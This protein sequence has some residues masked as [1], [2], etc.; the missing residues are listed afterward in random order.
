[1]DIPIVVGV[2]TATALSLHNYF[3]TELDIYFEAPLM[4]IFFLLIGRSVEYSLRDRI[5]DAASILL[6]QLQ[7][8]VW[9]QQGNSYNQK[10]V[11][12]INTGDVIRIAMG[13]KIKLDGLLIS[14][15]NAIIDNS[16]FSG[17]S[18]PVHYQQGSKIYAGMVNLGDNI[19]IR[20]TATGGQTRLAKFAENIAKALD[21]R[22]KYH[23]LAL[24]I[25]R[26]YTPLVHILALLTFGLWFADNQTSWQQAMTIAVS[27]L[28]IT[29]PCALGLATPLAIAMTSYRLLKQGILLK[30][31]A[32]IERAMQV[33]HIIFDKTGTLTLAEFEFSN[34]DSFDHGV[35]AI[36]KALA[37]HS[38]HP[39]C[40]SLLTQLAN[41]DAIANLDNIKEHKGQGVSAILDGKEVK[42][43]NANFC[44]VMTADQYSPLWLSIDG[45]TFAIMMRDTIKPD[46]H[47]TIV[48]LRHMGYEI[49]LISGDIPPIVKEVADK[50][51]IKA[52]HSQMSHTQKYQYVKH[53]TSQHGTLMIGDG[54]NDAESLAVATASIA[55][56]KALD[57]SQNAADVIIPHN[58]LTSVIS[59]LRIAYNGLRTIKSNLLVALV[60]NVCVVP[61]AILGFINPPLAAIFM[62]V[63]SITVTLMS[64]F[65]YRN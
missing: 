29:C 60:Y 34:K 51:A 4:L 19:Y 11:S 38:K 48:K 61:F 15:E 25:I 2:I 27:V 22:N 16:A 57:V 17:E 55:P 50:L 65:L 21:K 40:L 36:I 41:V 30:N 10:W 18:L 35:L 24:R 63:S 53:Q 1:M 26:Y 58:K 46:A 56:A 54:L 9:V 42:L 3:Y 5:K 6:E 8:Y 31:S 49:S 59:F 52:Y 33:Q 37:S 62:A 47:D 13:E 7:G 12:E 32:V 20:V 28:I 23:D 45:V 14:Q 44:T 43:G 64:L 39:L